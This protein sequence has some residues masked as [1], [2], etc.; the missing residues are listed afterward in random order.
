M[1][2]KASWIIKDLDDG[3]KKYDC[4]NCDHKCSITLTK[5]DLKTNKGLRRNWKPSCP[6]SYAKKEDIYFETKDDLS[7]T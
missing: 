5:E 6:A 2:L 1:E 4:S 7:D 3:S